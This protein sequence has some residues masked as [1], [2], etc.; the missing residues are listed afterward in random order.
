M[1]NPEEIVEIL[2]KEFPET[3]FELINDLLEKIID[4]DPLTIHKICNFL[5]TNEE[6]HFDSLMNLSGV[7]DANGTKVK[8]ADGTEIING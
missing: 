7:D 5:R 4:T 2:K 1:K 6:L 8:D 3:K